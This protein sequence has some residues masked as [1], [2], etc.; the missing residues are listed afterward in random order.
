MGANIYGFTV[1]SDK[2]SLEV[3][4]SLSANIG[5][6]VFSFTSEIET[7]ICESKQNT[8]NSLWYTTSIIAIWDSKIAAELEDFRDF[9]SHSPEAFQ[10]FR[11]SR[12]IQHIHLLSC[13]SGDTHSQLESSCIGRVIRAGHD[14][15][16]TFHPTYP[17]IRFPR[18]SLAR[19]LSLPLL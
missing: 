5:C 19:C 14:T 9:W 15:P 4:T 6:A 13:T 3:V 7:I 18:S 10:F 12:L 1:F 17:L 2:I 16:I 8:W 11:H